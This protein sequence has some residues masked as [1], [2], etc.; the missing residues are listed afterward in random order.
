MTPESLSQQADPWHLP[1]LPAPA[2]GEEL[3]Q[4][5]QARY[6]RME[7][8]RD[9][10]GLERTALRGKFRYEDGRLVNRNTGRLIGGKGA[11]TGDGKRRRAWRGTLLSRWIFL[12]HHGWVPVGKYVIDH[13]DN[14]SLND[15][16]ENLQVLHFVENLN[17]DQDPDRPSIFD[18][19][20]E[21]RQAAAR[22]GHETQRRLGIGFYDPA[23]RAKSQTPAARAKRQA[24]ILVRGIKSPF[25]DPAIR[26]KA[27]A[28]RRA[29]GIKSPFA[30]PAVQAKA[31]ATR[32]ARGIKS[33][34]ADP[35]VQAKAAATRR[36]RGIKSPFA[37]P[38]IRAKAAATRR[39]RGIKSPFA[40]PA[41]QAKAAATRRARGIKS[42][43]ADPAVQAK[44]AATRRAR[45]IKS[46]FADPA[47]RAKAQATRQARRR[48]AAGGA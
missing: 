39:A 31:A 4:R 42:S 37:D 27:A 29:R 9:I 13:I 45:G 32:R 12:Y 24:T 47:I 36:A 17:K 1:Q 41:V 16:I 22:R 7:V 43:F 38:A 25:A 11:K 40:D 35:A 26:A 18:M 23:T 3:L 14:D 10:Q 21:Q 44:A 15:R 48:Q 46:P 30:D 20:R 5:C 6:P 34:F 28:T 8:R 19:T 2:S 33:S